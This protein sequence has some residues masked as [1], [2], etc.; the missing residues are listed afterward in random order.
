MK[1]KHLIHL[2]ALC[3]FLSSLHAQTPPLTPSGPPSD[4]ATAMKSLN[5][6][7]P[8]TIIGSLPYTITQS[9]SYYLAGNM[10]VPHDTTAI[11]IEAADVILDLGGFTISS[12]AGSGAGAAC[13]TAT[14]AARSVTIRNGNIRS[15]ITSSGSG[16]FSFSGTGFSDGIFLPGNSDA[17]RSFRVEHITVRGTTDGIDCGGISGIGSMAVISNCH[18]HDAPHYGIAGAGGT[19]TDCTVQRFDQYGYGIAGA[20]ITRCAVSGGGI[21]TIGILGEVV[22]ACNA[23]ASGTGAKCI[24]GQSIS[25]CTADVS[26][27]NQ[28]GID[29]TTVTGCT[30][31]MQD[32]SGITGINAKSATNCHVFAY[33]GVMFD[34]EIA[35]GCTFQTVG[36]ATNNITHK[37]N[38]P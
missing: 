33:G 11:S 27:N 3:G 13:I 32:R 6:V 22:S 8:R 1:T 7:E 20:V 5:Q 28:L 36:G 34:A 18:V 12:T 29:G 14:N 17:A 19:V 15:G 2:A 31:S 16:P 10:S 30:V 9:G 21:T 4:P 35:N 25:N 37:Y 24:Q 23:S 38:M 26:A